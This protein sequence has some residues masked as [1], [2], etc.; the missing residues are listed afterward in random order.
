MAGE[1]VAG[2]LAHSLALLSDAAHMLTDAAA[3]GLAIAAARLARRP[4]R[5]ALTFGLGRA[6]I[7]SAQANGATLVALAL[8]IAYSALRRLISPSHVHAWPVVVLALAGVLVSAAATLVLA[9]AG[10]ESLNIEGSFRHILTDMYAFLGTLAA[11]VVILLSGFYRA[12]AIAALLVA[13]LMLRAGAGL[14][15]AAGRVVLE[16]APALLVPDEIGHVLALQ[17]GVVEVHDLHVWEV[18]SALCA[19]SAHV[20]VAADTDCHAVRRH[21]EVLLGE[22]FGLEHTTLQ[23]DHACDELLALELS[24]QLRVR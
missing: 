15:R 9:G 13:V 19:V 5:G 6:E 3:L 24:P 11:G 10:R 20:L 17:P 21:L 22:R 23:V 14:L 18:S 2:I 8:L 12:D 1:V 7:L 16:A 4:A